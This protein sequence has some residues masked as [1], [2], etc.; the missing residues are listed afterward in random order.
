MFSNLTQIQVS[1]LI[2]VL[3][4]TPFLI[5]SVRNFYLAN[6]SKHWPK[7]S[8]T[9]KEMSGFGKK[10]SVLYEYTVNRDTYKSNK[11]CFTNTNAPVSES[12][13]EFEKK[14]ALN[15]II[16]VFYNP[17]NPKQ[18]VLE[19]GRKDGLLQSI[20]FLGILFVFGCLAV[21]YQDL[22]LQILDPYIQIV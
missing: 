19:P 21:L 1:G 6:A 13:S 22:F 8:G 2:V 5:K 11:I 10:Y 17:Q 12:A 15:Q 7:I 18:S 3:V 4:L 14:Y 16:N 9:I 20:I